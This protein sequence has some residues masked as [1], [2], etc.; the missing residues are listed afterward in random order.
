MQLDPVAYFL[1]EERNSI[2]FFVSYLD[3]RKS[4]LTEI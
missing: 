3:L 4:E 1:T 2:T